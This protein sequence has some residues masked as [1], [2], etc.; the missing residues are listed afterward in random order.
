M[1]S[2]GCETMRVGS[3][4]R[5]RPDTRGGLVCAWIARDESMASSRLSSSD[6][7]AP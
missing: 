7:L 5:L 6:R 1:K 2:R 4:Q 3:E